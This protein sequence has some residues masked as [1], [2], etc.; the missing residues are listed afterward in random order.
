ML[1]LE[2]AR[3]SPVKFELMIFSIMDI[4]QALF[5]LL[6]AAKYLFFL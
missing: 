6:E 1:V 2:R 5:A 4:R 3:L